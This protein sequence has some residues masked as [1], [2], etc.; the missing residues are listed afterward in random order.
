[1]KLIFI[2]IPKT[3]GSSLSRYLFEL[4]GSGMWLKN[5]ELNKKNS[6]IWKFDF[7]SGH[8]TRSELFSWMEN[9]SLKIDKCRIL[10]V[11]RHPLDQLFSN[12]IFPFELK[13]RNEKISEKWMIDLLKNKTLSDIKLC[14]LLKK[15]NW[16]LNMQWQF[17]VTGLSLEEAI[18]CFDKI[19]IY[20]SVKE[21][22]NYCES[23]LGACPCDKVVYHENTNQQK[24]F[25]KDIFHSPKLRELIM[26]DHRL[27]M[28]LYIRF[29]SQK[30]HA[31]GLSEVVRF[32]PDT[33]EKLYEN[34]LSSPS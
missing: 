3:A 18:Q 1:M 14:N 29:I 28:E 13:S 22:F 10:T 12:L 6:N 5:S 20:P 25:P 11:I 31:S 15:Y 33:P 7:L 26:N 34:W 16:L 8:F 19:L 4:S 27:D 2:H 30:L 9:N 32:T 17:I 24:K 23:V 21:A